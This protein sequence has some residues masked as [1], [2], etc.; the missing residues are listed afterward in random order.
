MATCCICLSDYK[1]PRF[2]TARM[3]VCGTCVNMLNGA[4]LS[5]AEASLRKKQLWRGYL[6]RKWLTEL[7]SPNDQIARKA[8]WKLSTI[9]RYVEEEFPSWLNKKCAD[10]ADL[11]ME[12]RLIRAFRRGLV[13]QERK[14][15]RRPYNW[16]FV[17]LR[18]K[19][20]D[21]QAC[22]IC[23]SNQQKDAALVLHAHHIVFRSKSG[24]NRVANLITV[25]FDCHQ[26]LHPDIAIST[27]G[28]EEDGDAAPTENETDADDPTPIPPQSPRYSHQK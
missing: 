26:M 9:D 7:Q 6:E 4:T 15:L 18:I 2:S 17:A 28:G 12:I 21:G 13:C 22:R 3:V 19:H 14:V 24:T 10:P 5:P 25:C 27:M 20:E 1:S 23:G 11:S 8:E 16:T